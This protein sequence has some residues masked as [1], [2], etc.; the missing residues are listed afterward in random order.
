MNWKILFGVINK[1]ITGIM[2]I[3]LIFTVIAVISVRISGGEPTIFGYQLKTVLSGSMEPEI[4]T[5]SI[6]AI[7]TGGDMRRFDEGN[8]I[9]FWSKDNILITHRIF[10]VSGDGKQYLTKGDN[11]D[12]PDIEPVLSQNIVGQYT[13]YNLPFIGYITNFTHTKQGV[14]LL[15][16]PGVSLLIYSALNIRHVLRHFEQ[17]EKAKKEQNYVVSSQTEF[18]NF[19]NEQ[20]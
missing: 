15:I 11:N 4:Q 17:Q 18:K 8:I 20:K 9:T 14:V 6:I 3:V 7:K 2:F 13:G 19:N 10:E 1:T 12:G 16:I 5:G